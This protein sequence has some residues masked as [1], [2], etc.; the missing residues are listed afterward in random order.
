MERTSRTRTRT[1]S[2]PPPGRRAA[3]EPVGNRFCR[4]CPAYPLASFRYGQL[5]T[6]EIRHLCGRERELQQVQDW[7]GVLDLNEVRGRHANGQT[8][9]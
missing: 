7:L 4:Y 5:V 3:P 1:P 6:V 9:R 8:A 2:T